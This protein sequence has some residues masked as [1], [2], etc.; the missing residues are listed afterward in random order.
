MVEINDL[1]GRLAG[2]RIKRVRA[3]STGLSK[4]DESVDD[5]VII[6]RLARGAVEVSMV[7]PGRAPVRDEL[8]ISPSGMPSIAAKS[9]LKKDSNVR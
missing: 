1:G 8:K 3:V 2:V 5:A 7:V 6:K 9:D 4:I